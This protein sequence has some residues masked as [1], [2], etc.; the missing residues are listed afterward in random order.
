MCEKVEFKRAHPYAL[1]V[2]VL[3][4]G[5]LNGTINISDDYPYPPSLAGVPL[6]S[7]YRGEVQPGVGETPYYMHSYGY[8]NDPYA[9]YDFHPVRYYGSYFQPKDIPF[10]YAWGEF[11]NTLEKERPSHVAPT[12]EQA[13]LVVNRDV[14][15]AQPDML[16]QASMMSTTMPSDDRYVYAIVGALGLLILF[17]ALFSQKAR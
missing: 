14:A 8:N 15:N 4:E 2:N 9:Y 13:A 7:A 10:T 17:A 5:A 16:D 3:N 12:L 1:G 6:I 11:G